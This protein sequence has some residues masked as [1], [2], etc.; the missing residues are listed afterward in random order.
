MQLAIR[1]EEVRQGKLAT[2]LRNMNRIEGSRRLFRHIRHIEGK[3]KGDTTTQ[4]TVT[5][6]DGITTGQMLK[7]PLSMR[8]PKSIIRLNLGV[9][10]S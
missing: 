3:L 5:N 1:K 9:V 2:I 4:V 6:N 8:I 7:P 10:N